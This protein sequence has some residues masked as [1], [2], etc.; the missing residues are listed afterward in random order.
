MPPG[1]SRLAQQSVLA[2]TPHVAGS[3]PQLVAVTPSPVPV[4]SL[5]T[6]ASPLLPSSASKRSRPHAASAVI[7]TKSPALLTRRA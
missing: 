5:V 3:D 1:T 2:P 7:A 4:L 6:G